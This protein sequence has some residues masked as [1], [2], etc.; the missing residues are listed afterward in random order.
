M[1]DYKVQD[2]YANQRTN[3]TLHSYS[4]IYSYINRINIELSFVKPE[5][6]A[7]FLG[8]IIIEYQYHH[9][10]DMKNFELY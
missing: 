8:K 6:D 2:L 3:A 5:I 9:A 1:H 10:Q 7:K 4:H